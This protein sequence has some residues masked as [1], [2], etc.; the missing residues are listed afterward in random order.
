MVRVN[1]YYVIDV[2]ER[3]YTVKLDKHKTDKKGNAVYDVCGYYGT[4]EGA[5]KGVINSMNSKSLA[6]GIHTLEQAL[7]IVATNNKQFEEM[8]EKVCA[9]NGRCKVD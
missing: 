8:L 3:N 5:I 9:N 6:D 4:I 2:D 7:N 1:E